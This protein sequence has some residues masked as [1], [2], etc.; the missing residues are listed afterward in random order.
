M[1]SFQKVIKH[2]GLSADS[3]GENGWLFALLTCADGS[4]GD[5]Y[6]NVAKEAVKRLE[7]AGIGD[8]T[9]VKVRSMLSTLDHA[10][11]KGAIR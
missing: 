9:L 11:E 5:T 7:L 4:G 3:Q 6:T 1:N 8:H 10:I 2:L